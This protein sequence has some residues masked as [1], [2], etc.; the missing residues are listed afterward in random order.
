MWKAAVKHQRVEE[1][2]AAFVAAQEQ[3]DEVVE[4]LC[5]EQIKLAREAMKQIKL[6]REGEGAHGGPGGCRPSAPR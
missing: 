2:S 4:L 1:A 5:M 6:A 3:A